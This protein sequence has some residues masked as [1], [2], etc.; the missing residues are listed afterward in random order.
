MKFPIPAFLCLLASGGLSSAAVINYDFNFRGSPPATTD[1]AT[2]VGLGA[3][4]DSPGNT[5]WNGLRRSS[6]TS[7]SSESTLNVG[8]ED[9]TNTPLPGPFPVS[10]TIDNL[11]NGD[12]R[13]GTSVT[14]QEVGGAGLTLVDLMGDYVQLRSSDANPTDLVSAELYFQNLVAG[15]FYDVYF[16]SQGALLGQNSRFAVTDGVNGNIVSPIEQTGW[17]GV[18]G[19]DGDLV[20]GVEYVVLTAQANGSGALHFRW[21][22]D[23]TVSRFGALNAIQ[24]LPSAVPEPSVALLGVLGAFGLLA[25]R[26]R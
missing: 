15:Q 10:L 8:S 7:I 2:Y 25:R 23:P 11:V 6:S 13:Q 20:E 9:S 18:P 24:L 26:R 17:D 19:G 22:N 14:N 4:P 3:A 1:S 12:I 5:H 21:M 16:Y